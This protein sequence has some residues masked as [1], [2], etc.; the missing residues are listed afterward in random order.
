MHNCAYCT[1][2]TYDLCICNKKI[3]L[4]HLFAN[5][6]RLRLHG[7]PLEDAVES[8]ETESWFFKDIQ[9]M[10]LQLVVLYDYP[11]PEVPLLAQDPEWACLEVNV[12]SGSYG[13]KW[14]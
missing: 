2:N 13:N 12:N 3:S 5:V 8:H 1:Y 7:I 6:K 4:A 14:P 10:K 9:R 11:C